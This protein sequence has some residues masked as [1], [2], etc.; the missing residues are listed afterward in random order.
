M[1]PPGV[2]LPDCVAQVGEG[3]GV[4]VGAEGLAGEVWRGRDDRGRCWKCFF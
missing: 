3:G 2:E 4:P 1:G